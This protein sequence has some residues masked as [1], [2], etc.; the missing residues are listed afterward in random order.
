[1]RKTW[2]QSQSYCD[3][4]RDEIWGQAE[5]KRGLPHT[6]EGVAAHAHAVARGILCL[7]CF[8]V[9]LSLRNPTM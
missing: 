8:W 4:E 3:L 9:I 7:R 6:A 2:N 1:M 5:L